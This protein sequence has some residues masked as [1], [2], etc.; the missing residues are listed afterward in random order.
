MRLICSIPSM[1]RALA[2]GWVVSLFVLGACTNEPAAAPMG[3]GTIRISVETTSP[4]PQFV[5]EHEVHVGSDSAIVSPGGAV[6]FSDLAAGEY[7]VTL[8]GV[9][10]SCHV[11]ADGANRIVSLMGGEALE[12][13]FEVFC[14]ARLRDQIVLSDFNDLW[15]INPDGTAL[16]KLTDFEQ[17]ASIQ[18]ASVSPDGS[19]LAFGG[20]RSTDGSF[21]IYSMRFDGSPPARLTDDPPGDDLG[22]SWSPDG[23]SISYV[24]EGPSGPRVA[25]VNVVTGAT[26]FLT[27]P[28]DFGFIWNTSWSSFEDQVAF[29]YGDQSTW[30][31]GVVTPNGPSLRLPTEGGTRWASWA[32]NGYL[33]A[34]GHV[35]DGAFAEQLWIMD[36]SGRLL[37]QLTTD[38]VVARDPIWSPDGNHLAFEFESSET[39]LPPGAW[40]ID[41]DGTNRR[42]LVQH[43]KPVAWAPR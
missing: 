34:V 17:Q 3:P 35:P 39:N 5:V 14:V 24:A 1:P 33:L 11:L 8:G 26:T 43:L 20:T 7:E 38:A 16:I 10:N 13:D 2:T 30:G 25:V 31:I 4:T 41:A 29:T 32:P 9:P 36:N 23:T 15:A 42:L 21:N 40:I 19:T 27:N 12:V 28:G 22:P 6:T 37:L 18:P